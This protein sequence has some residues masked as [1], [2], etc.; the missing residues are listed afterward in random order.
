M[1][2]LGSILGGTAARRGGAR[3]RTSPFGYG[4]GGFSR[5]G[6]GRRP[7]SGGLLSSPLARMALGAGA[8]YAARRYMAGR[9]S[10]AYSGSPPPTN[11]GGS[12]GSF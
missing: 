12:S 9:S 2:L 7:A 8:A 1:G 10:S 4:G 5:G 6:F 11:T 3:Y